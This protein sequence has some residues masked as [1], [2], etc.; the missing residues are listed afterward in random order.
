MNRQKSLTVLFL[1]IFVSVVCFAQGAPTTTGSLAGQVPLSGRTGQS[2]SVATQQTPIPGT[3]QSVNTV[4]TT[5][6]VQGP[7]SQSALGGK[8]VEGPLSLR[9][10]IS[11]GL[12]Y[13][14][15]TVGLSNAAMQAHGQMRVARSSLLPNLNGSL[16][17]VAQQSN[18]ASQGLRLPGIPKIVGP[19]NY[20][21]LRATLS[22]S[23]ADLTA[24]NNYRSAQENLKATQMAAKDARDLVVLAVGGAYLQ[25][26]AAQARVESAQAQVE[27]A[28]AVFD[29]T[30]Q[31]R[32]A[33]LNAQFD[34]NRS[35]VEYQTQ[36]QRLTTLQNDLAKQKIN[37][38]RMMGLPP[39]IHLQLADNVPYS[40][41]PALSYE[42]AVREALETRADLKSAEAAAR[43]ADRAHTAARAERLPS[44]V[45]AA[46]YGAIGVNPAQTHGTF[47]VTGTVRFPIW[48][49][50]RTEG[51]I[52]Q[53]QAAVN[54]R[55][56]ELSDIR[57]RI[58]G[59]LKDAYL[60]MESA[61]SQLQVAESNQKVAR[62]N[63]D[64]TRQ[65]LEAGIADSVE[66]TR[67][68]ETTASADLDY[69]TSLLAFNLAK[70]SVARALG[71]AEDNL[72]K[73]LAVR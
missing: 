14:L 55:H 6:S 48:Q 17:E 69:I 16:R 2:G 47:N 26:I 50:G 12:E 35:Q 70:L 4:N 71:N 52:E 66:G 37:L 65:R 31:R 24:W 63:L 25:V 53:A 27:T 23:I 11:R 33:G 49:G 19:Y 54:Q 13:N 73:Y 42:D 7:Y 22:Q 30:K 3:T 61:A 5:I 72:S 68:L 51:D 1:C 28:R 32:E 18:L 10:A 58:Q 67:A 9:E 20:V 46:D 38:C 34:V 39:D 36:Q 59:E 44:V 62:E 43:A 8:P 41:A 21:D 29:Q 40:P 57:S 56:A 15:G 60:D 45:V 64:L